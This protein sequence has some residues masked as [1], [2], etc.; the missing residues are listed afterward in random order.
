MNASFKHPER[1]L[2]LADARSMLALV[3]AASD[4]TLVVGGDDVINDLSSNLDDQFTSD[5]PAWRGRSLEQVVNVK[6]GRIL[7]QWGGVKTGH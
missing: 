2:P 5:I 3:A 1:H 4:L 7:G 6:G